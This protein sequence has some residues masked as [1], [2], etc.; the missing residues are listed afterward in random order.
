MC[1]SCLGRSCVVV[2]FYPWILAMFLVLA[3]DVTGFVTYLIDFINVMVR[4][5]SQV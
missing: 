1:I 4:L 2:G 3:L 5:I